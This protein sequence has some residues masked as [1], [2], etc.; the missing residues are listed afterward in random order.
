V[1]KV[2]ERLGCGGFD[3]GD[4]EIC[5]CQKLEPWLVTGRAFGRVS[6]RPLGCIGGED[7]VDAMKKE[8]RAGFKS[9]QKCFCVL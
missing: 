7:I 5:L 2:Y 1:D 8:G 4:D 6:L 9:G 3:G